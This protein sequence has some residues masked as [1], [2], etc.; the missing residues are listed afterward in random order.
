MTIL[1][2]RELAVLGR[3]QIS[4]AEARATNWVG[5]FAAAWADT[6]SGSE[7]DLK[8]EREL[9][10]H[11]QAQAFVDLVAQSGAP[12]LQDQPV[13]QAREMTVMLSQLVGSG[14]EMFEIRNVSVPVSG[15]NI[16][17]T[18]YRP[19]DR[20]PGLI[21]YFHGGGWV[22]GTIDDF[23]TVCQLLAQQSGCDVLSVDYRL[24][25]S[26][27]SPRPQTT[28]TTRSSGPPKTLL[29]DAPSWWWAI[30]PEATWPQSPRFARAIVKV[31]KSQRRCFA[32]R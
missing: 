25:P 11:P 14:P 24:A 10:L 20:A 30:A 12:P 27:H 22:V 18:L 6:A 2:R 21:V 32:I 29:R 9:T 31:R 13:G 8:E 16:R 3:L 1:D 4:G 28:A 15:A 23:G 7:A 19:V 17:G 5:R 26:T